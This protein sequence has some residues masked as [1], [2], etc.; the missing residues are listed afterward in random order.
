MQNRHANQPSTDRIHSPKIS[1]IYRAWSNSIHP[2]T[3][4]LL[5]LSGPQSGQRPA[6]TA[7]PSYFT[8]TI[9]NKRFA[10]HLLT[11]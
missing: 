3:D 5:I 6:A 9:A 7:N 1:R 4:F 11:V 2:M 10:S 8:Q